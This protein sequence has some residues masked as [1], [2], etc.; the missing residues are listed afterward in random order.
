MAKLSVVILAA[1]KGTRMYSNRPKVLHHLGGKSLVQHVIDSVKPL[2]P[3]NLYVIYGHGKDQLE[4][5]LAGQG[6]ELILQEKQLGTGHAVQQAMPYLQD[7]DNVLILYADTPLISA[8]T[9]NDLIA[10]KPSKGL[11]LLTVELTD[12]TGYGR[13][14]REQGNIVG[15]VEQKDASE[16]QKQIHEVNTGIMLAPGK[17]LKNWLGRLNNH[18]AQQEYYLTDVIKLAY[19]DG[20]QIQATHPQNAFEAQGVN[21]RLQLAELERIYQTEQAQQLLLAGVTLYD[22]D[23]F[24]LRG[25]LIHGKDV[26]IDTNVIIEGHVELGDRVYIGSGCVLKN[27]QIGDDC[28]ISPYSVIEDSVLA[29]A[30]TVGPFARLRPGT[31]LAE[32]AHVGNFVEL[33][34]TQLGQNSKAGHLS[35][36]GDSEIG[37]QVNIGAGTI[38]CNYDGANKFKTIIGDNVFIG[39][40]TQL[41]AP[42]T[43]AKGATIGAGTTVTE[44]I[45]EN[46]LVISRIKQQHIQGWQRPTKQK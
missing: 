10:H 46:E 37:A 38:T 18:N 41:I 26:V 21:D 35:Y 2:N 44:D 30:C 19:H 5:A 33:K 28:Q 3:D 20:Y 32:K 17:A 6:V 36:L 39:S 16:A 45:G 25:T 24:D 13:I 27:C 22:P 7:D 40:D 1:G 12:P 29:N 14:V 11:S 15:I 4:Q 43:V 34:N 42:V 23:R 9:L 8:A 31:Q